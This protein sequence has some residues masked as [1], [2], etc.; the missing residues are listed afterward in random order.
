MR[1]NIL[2]KMRKI[3]YALCVSMLGAVP[4][5][6]DTIRYTGSSTIG[7]FIADAAAVYGQASFVIS[8]IPESDGGEQCAIKGSCDIGGVAREVDDDAIAAAGVVKTLI[9]RDMIA[10]LVHADNPVS[11]ISSDSLQSIF[12]GELDNWNLLGGPDLPIKVYVVHPRSATHQVFKSMVLGAQDYARATVIEPDARMISVIASEPGAIGQLST[13][14]LKYRSQDI[15]TLEVDGHR[16]SAADAGYPI[17]RP[18]YLLTQGEPDG[19]VGDFISWAL[20]PEGQAV[21]ENR[22]AGTR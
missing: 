5:Y 17:S 6:A 15:K 22:F 2:G 19:T 14:F 12:S 11:E 4:V 21:L 3:V 9:A 13:S 10:A 18:L 20:S 8:T 1:K 7:K 16:A